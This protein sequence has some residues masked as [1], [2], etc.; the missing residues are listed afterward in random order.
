MVIIHTIVAHGESWGASP[1]NPTPGDHL[2]P[3]TKSQLSYERLRPIVDMRYD[4]EIRLFD[5]H[6]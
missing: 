2:L 6:I 4:N 3:F 5:K 1:G